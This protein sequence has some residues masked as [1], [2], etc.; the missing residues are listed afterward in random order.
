MKNEVIDEKVSV[1]IVKDIARR[2]YDIYL[3]VMRN[4]D[5]YVAKPTDLIFEKV[6]PSQAHDGPTLRFT[7]EH[8]SSFLNSLGLELAESGYF[9]IPD[10][11]K[12]ELLATKRELESARAYINK[13]LSMVDRTIK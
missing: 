10:I 9:N 5:T 11:S 4:G 2:S 6:D 12:G 13:L 1:D 3:S 8:G 7:H